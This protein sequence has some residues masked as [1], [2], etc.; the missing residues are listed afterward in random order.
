MPRTPSNGIE[1][2]YDTFGD[3][4]RPALLLIMGLG[5]QMTAW[6]P[7]F[8][9]SLADRGFHVIRYDNR[10]SGL[11]TALDEVPPLDIRAVLAGDTSTVPYRLADM[12]RDAVGLLDALGVEAAHVVGASMGGMIAQQL[13]IDHPDR[14]RSLC[15]IMSTTGDRSVGRATPEALAVLVAPPARDREEAVERAVRSATVLGSPAHPVPP[16]EL[17]ERAA[18]AHDRS[19]RPAGFAR[20]YAAILA[21]PD[22]TPLL[23]SVTAP[24]LVVH[25]AEDPLVDRSGGEATAAAIPGAELLV[26]PGM[27]HDLPEP[28]WPPI[29]D[30]IA[31]NAARAAD[32]A[33]GGL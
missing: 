19:H 14:V 24:T 21:S 9:R 23:R 33:T 32:H 10:D 5:A 2:E 15:S 11:S 3:P 25:G 16:E 7:E 6:R 30:A 12:A 17:R 22:R 28:L 26:V 1:L 20:Q 4:D 18:A 27:G 8:C 31:R 13:V 29:V